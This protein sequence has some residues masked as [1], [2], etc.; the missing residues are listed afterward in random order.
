MII[1]NQFISRL[2]LLGISLTLSGFNSIDQRTPAL[3]AASRALALQTESEYHQATARWSHAKELLGKKYSKSVVKSGESVVTI[4]K[5]VQQWTKQSLRGPWKTKAK[6]IAQTILEESN[7]HK[8]DPILILAIIHS[9]S[10]FRPDAIGPLGEIGLMQLRPATAEWIARKY[11]IPWHGIESLKN[12]ILNLKIGMAYLAYLRE[13]FKF[14]SQHYLAAYNMG[15]TNV[16][17]AL[18]T[19]AT[20]KVYPTRVLQSYIRLY[21]QLENE[22]KSPSTEYNHRL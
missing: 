10:S 18:K 15:S 5:T 3:E 12:P 8:L 13:D 14:Q 1:K 9:E 19:A 6:Q 7:R 4:D 21:T 17:R 22:L 16:R 2:S 20:P 11:Q